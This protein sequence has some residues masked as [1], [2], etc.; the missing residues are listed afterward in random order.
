MNTLTDG[1]KAYIGFITGNSCHAYVWT[2]LTIYGADKMY[3]GTGAP[4]HLNPEEQDEYLEMWELQY[5]DLRWKDLRDRIVNERKCCAKCGNTQS[6]ELHHKRYIND[7]L[8]WEYEDD[9]LEVLCKK[10]HLNEHGLKM[11]ENGTIDPL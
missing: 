1:D 5:Q 3:G 4:T 11:R 10:C 8:L 9:D 2:L 6:L 7:K